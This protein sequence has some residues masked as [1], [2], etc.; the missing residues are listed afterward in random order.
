MEQKKEKAVLAIGIFFWTAI[1]VGFCGIGIKY[2]LLGLLMLCA[3]QG[4]LNK[5]LSLDKESILLL[6]GM[7]AYSIGSQADF[8]WT[9]RMTFIPFLFYYYGKSVIELYDQERREQRTKVLVMIL[10]LGLLMGGILNAV[11]WYRHGFEG[12]RRWAEFWSGRI[13]PATQHVFWGVLIS[14]LMFYGLYYWKKNKLLNGLVVLGGLWSVW[15]SLFTKSRTLVIIFALVLGFNIVLYC[16][17]N[18]HDEDKRYKIKNIWIGILILCVLAI[19]AYC[20]N[21]G[22]ISDFMKSSI[23]GRDGGIFHNVRFEA[24]I[25]VMKQLFKYPFGGRQMDLAGLNYAHNVWLDMANTAGLIPFILVAIY[26]V[27]TAYGLIKLIR[28]HTVGQEIKYLIA[29]AYISLFLYYMVEPAFDANL[30]YWSFWML[31]CGLVKGNIQNVS[32]MKYDITK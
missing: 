25:S 29:S 23:W 3:T 19:A 26:T 7:L 20:F 4:V 15:F 12:G 27:V 10:S 11:S 2:I 9:V 22:G 31:I 30:M 21:V 5:K 18:W 1:S 8:G 24:Q 32:P 13:L 28:S 6:T 17:L 16:C 14:G